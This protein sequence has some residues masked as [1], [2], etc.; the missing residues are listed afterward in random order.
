M[1]S[2]KEQEI[3]SK[4]RLGGVLQV[5][6]TKVFGFDFFKKYPEL[7]PE[8][9]VN[10]IAEEL[11]VELHKILCGE[12]LEKATIS[13]PKDWWEAV[14]ERFFPLWLRRKFPVEYTVRTME[15]IAVYPKISLKNNEHNVVFLIDKK[16][17]QNDNLR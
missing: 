4:I 7:R 13:Y 9:V 10:Q 8:I 1:S 6:K 14:K 12:V 17:A 15:A 5:K 11:A 3:M 2:I 16:V